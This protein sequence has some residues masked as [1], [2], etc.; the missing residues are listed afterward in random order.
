MPRIT[1]MS[2]VKTV[3][4][5]NPEGVPETIEGFANLPS[6]RRFDSGE[7]EPP[8]PEQIKA[9]RQLLG[10]SQNDLAKLVGVTWNAKKG[11]TAV[12]KWE[13]AEGKSEHRT[14]SYA[15]WRGMLVTAGVVDKF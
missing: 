1:N 4:L 13:T 2:E 6:A 9:L 7:Y 8:T 5:V 10:Y 15:Q 11:S 14:I 12:R 3:Y